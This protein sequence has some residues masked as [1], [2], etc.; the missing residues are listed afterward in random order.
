M[1]TYLCRL[2][3]SPNIIRELA[4]ER[5]KTQR[6]KV[7]IDFSSPNIAKPF[8]IGNMR[9]TLIGMF[10]QRLHRSLDHEIVSVN[11]LGD[12]G[13]QFAYLATG[14]PS[15]RPITSK[16]DTMPDS[17]RIR[18]L[19]NCYVNSNHKAKDNPQY[20][21]EVRELFARMEKDLSEKRQSKELE[22]WQ[23]IRNVSLKYLNAFY[24]RFNVNMDHFIGESEYVR[25]TNV[26]V[27]QL[28]AQGIVYKN[29]AGLYVMDENGSGK[30]IAC[31]LY[32]DKMFKADSYLYVVDRAQQRHFEQLKQILERIGREDLAQKIHHISYGRVV[33]LS[34]RKGQTEAVE[35]I[36]AKGRQLALDYVARSPTV[37]V[38]EPRERMTVAEN[39]AVSTI[40]VSDLKRAKK[41]EYRFSFD[42]AFSENQN[43]AVLLQERH[44][45]L[46]SIESH[47][48]NI[49]SSLEAITTD[50]EIEANPE[51]QRLL[52]QLRDFESILVSAFENNEPAHLTVY[53]M[54]LANISGSA[55]STLQVKDQP[56]KLA[57]Q[58]LLLLSATRH[59]LAE[60]M[61]LLG[62]DP[63]ERM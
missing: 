6:Q 26:L 61:R 62:I 16:W 18:L 7:V 12:W 24:T 57:A 55:A 52:H 50:P 2:R 10:I 63:L 43:N 33:G 19:T 9:S 21:A 28:L 29:S 23:E 11:H 35:E 48:S 30:E 36:V 51:A 5:L 45:R 4:G 49:L 44:S 20:Q 27:D 54:R 39:L 13:T 32:R 31:I 25:E 60:G 17:E 15:A 37:R 40:I 41:S 46:Y 59:V 53:L 3:R 1:S 34:T 47:N 42:N 38:G 14:W 56:E 58:R 8:H 22:L